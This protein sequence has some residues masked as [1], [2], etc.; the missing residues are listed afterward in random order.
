VKI[1]IAFAVGAAI[2]A[3]GRG[4]YERYML[5]REFT[6]VTEEAARIRLEQ[7]AFRRTLDEL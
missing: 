5:R 1:F 4:T 7:A 3:F 2:G 6:A